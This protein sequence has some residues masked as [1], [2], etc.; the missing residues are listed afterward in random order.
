MDLGRCDEVVLPSYICASVLHAV[1]EVGARPVFADVGPDMQVTAET[2]SHAMTGRTRCVIVAHL[3]SNT[4]PIEEIQRMLAGSG[5]YLID[6]AAQSFGARRDGRPVGTFGDCGIVSCGPGKALAGAAGGALVTNDEEIYRRA[7][8]IKLPWEPARVVASRAI[9]FWF[10][11]RFR[12]YTLPAEIVL[13]RLRRPRG[14]PPHRDCVMSNLDAAIGASQLR[15][16]AETTSQR[17][18]NALKLLEALGPL[19]RFNIT[20]VSEAST[21]IKIVLVLP[22]GCISAGEVI[23]AFGRAGVE[24]QR[25]YRPLHLQDGQWDRRLPVTEA[26]W[27]RVVCIPV[28]TELRNVRRLSRVL[29]PLQSAASGCLSARIASA[30]PASRTVPNP[31]S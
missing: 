30:V 26:L 6:D 31:C 20:D 17:R 28:Q 7:A 29:Q 8:A 5:V 23:S 19:A 24:C 13:N 9:S 3:F 21:V 2:V 27:D 25:G 18:Q 1:R 14:E 12:K 11:R 15:R 4:A 16:L 22:P 10:L